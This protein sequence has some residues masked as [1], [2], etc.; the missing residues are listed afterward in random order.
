MSRLLKDLTL[1]FQ[2]ILNRLFLSK[3]NRPPISL[4]KV[5]RETSNTP[6]RDSKIIVSVGTVTDDVRQLEIPKLTVAALRFTRAAK[7]RILNAGGE[8]LT[9]D[10]LALRAPA[11]ANTVLLRGVKTSRE[12]NKHFGMGKQFEICMQCFVDNGR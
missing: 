8:A 1:L 11:G 9:L 7:D 5:I 2:V 3:T 10:Q 12:A 6:D 4:S